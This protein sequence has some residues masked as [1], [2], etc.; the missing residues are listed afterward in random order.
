MAGTDPL[1]PV[2]KRRI[3]PIRV[4]SRISILLALVVFSASFV[5][6]DDDCDFTKQGM[7]D[8]VER[9]AVRFPGAS[10]NLAEPRAIWV[11]D[12][13]E[14]EYYTIGGC[15]DLGGA[16]GRVTPMSERRSSDAVRRVALELAKRF[17]P[18]SEAARISSA[19][20]NGSYQTNASES[21]EFIFI[22]HPFGEIVITHRFAVGSD[23]VEIAWP[24]I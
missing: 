12:D 13:G 23:T 5:Q 18:E 7:I 16:A 19:F 15:Y 11:R 2:E 3:N 6:A 9:I 24:I 17:L 20:K 1:Q 8:N 4:R 10:V 14:S 22:G 21:E